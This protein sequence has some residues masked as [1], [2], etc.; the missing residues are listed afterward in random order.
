MTQNQ[1]TKA[2]CK[3]LANDFI[4]WLD[5][6]EITYHIL[7]QDNTLDA[8]DGYLN[9]EIDGFEKG[10]ALLFVDGDFCG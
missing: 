6:N 9:L 3:M 7:D 5:H 10:E 8:N 1:I 4:G 2:A